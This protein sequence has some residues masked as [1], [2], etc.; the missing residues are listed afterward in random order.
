MICSTVLDRNTNANTT[1]KSLK[2][3]SWANLY[4]RTY[5]SKHANTLKHR[6][7]NHTHK[8]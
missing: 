4:T 8:S 5:T 1:H 6:Q 3:R 7:D 2:H